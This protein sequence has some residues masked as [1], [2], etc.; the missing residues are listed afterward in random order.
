LLWPAIFLFL[1]ATAAARPARGPGGGGG[2][3]KIDGKT[4]ARN[5]DTQFSKFCF[6]FFL[7]ASRDVKA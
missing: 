5:P 4:R 6:E 2:L 1:R 7:G 3:G